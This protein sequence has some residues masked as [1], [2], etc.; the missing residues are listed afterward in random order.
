MKHPENQQDRRV[1]PYPEEPQTRRELKTRTYEYTMPFNYENISVDRRY[2][3]G[4][5][6]GVELFPLAEV[7]PPDPSSGKPAEAIVVA[8]DSP[9]VRVVVIGSAC[10]PPGYVTLEADTV[11]GF[12]R[13]QEKAERL[14]EVD[15][16]MP[17]RF[18]INDLWGMHLRFDQ[19][20]E[21]HG[22]RPFPEDIP[23]KYKGRFTG[24]RC[25]DQEFPLTGMSCAIFEIPDSHKVRISG[26]S[27][28]PGWTTDNYPDDAHYSFRIIRTT[29]LA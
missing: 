5:F 6:H 24:Y 10:T 23:D 12:R 13:T 11:E 15:G 29:V 25:T 27:Q 28:I 8:E 1:E 9:I 18:R 7:S 19:W 20:A 22:G 4:E 16:I 2:R 14:A 17:V 21:P 26:G 3:G